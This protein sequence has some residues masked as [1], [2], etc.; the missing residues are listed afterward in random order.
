MKWEW[1]SQEYKKQK[2]PLSVSVEN[3]VS[4]PIHKVWSTSFSMNNICISVLLYAEATPA[5]FAFP[6]IFKMLACPI[7]IPLGQATRVKLSTIY[8]KYEVL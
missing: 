3:A 5:A 2:Y 6:S 8:S 4:S 7:L 1:E